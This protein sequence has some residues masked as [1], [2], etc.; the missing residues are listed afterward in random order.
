M[1]Q[2]QSIVEHTSEGEACGAPGTRGCP[3][4]PTCTAPGGNSLR[5]DAYLH[6]IKCDLPGSA[7][8][9]GDGSNTTPQILLEYKAAE[10]D[11]SDTLYTST[12]L[13]FGKPTVPTTPT[14]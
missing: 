14:S 12:D 4:L 6:T 11:P 7:E 1:G 10:P 8:W 2:Y 13:H 5:D 3:A 9:G